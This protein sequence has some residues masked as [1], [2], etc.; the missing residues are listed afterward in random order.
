MVSMSQ[1]PPRP[2][3]YPHML[4]IVLDSCTHTDWCLIAK[5]TTCGF[6]VSVH[7]DPL[8]SSLQDVSKT[9]VQIQTSIHSLL[10]S[11]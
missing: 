7:S 11:R 3:R 6:S 9:V 2:T 5:P 8:S 10:L 1:I 4:R